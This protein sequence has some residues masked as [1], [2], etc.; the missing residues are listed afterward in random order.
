MGDLLALSSVD[1]TDWLDR[2]SYHQVKGEVDLAHGRSAEAL[3]QFEI[4]AGLRGADAYSIE[5]MAHAYSKMKNFALAEK[6]Y[7]E[8]IQRS[9]LG[10]EGQQYSILAY[11]ELGKIH[12]QNG[13]RDKA[14]ERFRSFL[15]I[16]KDA[17]PDLPPVRDSR[18]RL[19]RLESPE[20]AGASIK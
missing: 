8:L 20:R 3:K 12:E 19:A 9:E 4:S 18:A 7:E 10:T 5:S 14:A 6:K 17:D 13:E 15:S 2:A 11:Y 16:W 1:R